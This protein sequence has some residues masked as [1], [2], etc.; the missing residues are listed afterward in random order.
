[1]KYRIKVVELSDGNKE[2]Y[3]QYGFLFFWFN[4]EDQYKPLFYKSLI[5]CRKFI[6][7][8]IKLKKKETIRYIQIDTDSNP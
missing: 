8:Q 4:Y 1:M 5:D 2:Y 6:D 3:P 7:Y